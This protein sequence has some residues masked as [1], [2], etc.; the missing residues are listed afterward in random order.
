MS[1][2]EVTEI[3]NSAF[4]KFDELVKDYVDNQRL[5]QVVALVFHND[6][7]IYSKKWG[8]ADIEIKKEVKFDDIFRIASMTKPI[9]TLGALMLLEK[10]E[11]YIKTGGLKRI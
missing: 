1:G 4:H 11:F 7:I 6:H 8:F 9:V 10:E 5:P 3:G 2:L